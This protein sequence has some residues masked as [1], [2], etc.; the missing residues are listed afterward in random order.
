MHI[1][2]IYPRLFSTMVYIYYYIIESGVV[3]D[4]SRAMYNHWS[5]TR[6]I[7]VIK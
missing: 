2:V 5:S 4:F 6:L 7:C 1:I 3:N